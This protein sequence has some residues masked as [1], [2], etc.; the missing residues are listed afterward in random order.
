MPHRGAGSAPR[1]GVL[2]SRA[3]DAGWIEWRQNRHGFENQVGVLRF[4][5]PGSPCSS[6]LPALKWKS[7]G[8]ASVRENS[9]D[10]ESR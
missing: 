3:G 4:K 6:W 10:T 1:E 7:F 9:D 2:L 5:R 8:S